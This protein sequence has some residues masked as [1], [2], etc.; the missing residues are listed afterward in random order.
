MC[1]CF[2]VGIVVFVFVFLGRWILYIYLLIVKGS[3]CS[4]RLWV[5]FFFK[6]WVLRLVRVIDNFF[7]VNVSICLFGGWLVVV[8]DVVFLLI[9]WVVFWI[10]EGRFSMG[11]IL[12]CFVWNI[13]G[14]VGILWNKGLMV[15]GN[16]F[17]WLKGILF[18]MVFLYYF[19]Y[20]FFN[21]CLV[22]WYEFCICY[23]LDCK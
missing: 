12:F 20:C 13:K 7:I 5:I 21:F 22:I 4:F 10:M 11:N 23:W 19:L 9:F 6:V 16:L 18:L 1:S 3:R 14:V 17:E 15:M 8:M 2:F